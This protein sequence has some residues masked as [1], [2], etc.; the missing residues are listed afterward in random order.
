MFLKQLLIKTLQAVR[1]LT[2]F[3]R[4]ETKFKTM[5]IILL[6]ARPKPLNIRLDPAVRY[7][8]EIT[9]LCMCFAEL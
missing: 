7:W 5:L 8:I 6:I 3:I 1:Q 4:N 2:K 9:I